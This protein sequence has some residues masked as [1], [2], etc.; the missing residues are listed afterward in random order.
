MIDCSAMRDRMPDV[1]REVGQWSD[2]EAAH[3]AHCTDC[4]AEWA[5]VQDGV[6]LHADLVVPTDRIAQA[7]LLRLRTE[8][9]VAPAI[10]RLPWRGSVIGL[11]AAAASVVLILYA[12]RAH[13]VARAE[14]VDTTIAAVLPELQGLNDSELEVVLQSLGPTAADAAPGLVPHLEDLTDTELEQLLHA[15][16]AE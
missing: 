11:M 5:I 1:A 7:V 12:P 8:R 2:A 4:A 9:A 14:L 15:K 6:A 10:R 13:R 16:G 3:L